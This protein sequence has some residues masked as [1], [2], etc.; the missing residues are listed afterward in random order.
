MLPGLGGGGPCSLEGF[1]EK[2]KEPSSLFVPK[3]LVW[4]ILGVL[5]VLGG[6]HQHSGAASGTKRD[7]G[8]R[9]RDESDDGGDRDEDRVDVG[10]GLGVGT[11]MMELKL[12]WG[13]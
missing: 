1:R 7:D 5:L 8:D 12:G 3:V 9:D 11:E 4:G 6:H 13:Q 10:G 2:T